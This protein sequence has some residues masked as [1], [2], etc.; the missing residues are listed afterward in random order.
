M[1][2]FKI[3]YSSH[4]SVCFIIACKSEVKVEFK[5][6]KSQAPPRAE[7][8]RPYL[9]GGLFPRLSQPR[10]AFVGLSKLIWT[11]PHLGV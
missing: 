1:T 10:C 8:K 3:I 7:T 2:A 11:I 6:E 5:Q 9:T 4:D